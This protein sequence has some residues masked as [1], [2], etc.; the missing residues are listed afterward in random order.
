MA[1]LPCEFIIFKIEVSPRQPL[2]TPIFKPEKGS[3]S[4]E[5]DPP[6]ERLAIRGCVSLSRNTAGHAAHTHWQQ[7]RIQHGR[8]C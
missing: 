5:N 4:E 7:S 1:S 6:I 3:K 2:G 8:L